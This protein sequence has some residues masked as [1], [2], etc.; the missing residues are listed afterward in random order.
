MIKSLLDAD[1]DPPPGTKVI[2]EETVVAPP[3]VE[4][5]SEAAPLERLAENE[6]ILEIPEIDTEY[7]N[8]SE[9]ESF[10]NLENVSKFENVSNLENASE[11]HDAA[12]VTPNFHTIVEHQIVEPQPEQSRPEQEKVLFQSDIAPPQ[13]VNFVP[14]TQAETIRKSGLAYAAAITLFGSV[15]FL[16]LIGWFVDLLLG[17]S[18][19]ATLGGIVLGSIIGFLQF[20][21]MTSQILKNK[22]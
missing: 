7:E 17:T 2:I 5:F 20:F 11:L 1:E 15:A 8:A 10:S 13:S 19:W 16:L 21:R 3:P 4:N 6:N 12:A 18:P 9:F 14:E 22:D